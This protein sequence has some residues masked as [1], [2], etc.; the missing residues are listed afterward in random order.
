MNKIRNLRQPRQRLP[1]SKKNKKWRK[2]NLD[3]ADGYSFYHNEGVRQSLKNKIINLNL[4]N[5]KVDVRDIAQV[6][7]P[8]H[9]DASFVPENIPHHPIV[10]PK[11]DLLVG[12]ES[13]RRFDW[14]VL[15]SNSDAISKKEEEKKQFL[16][17]K[18]TEYLKANYPKEELE[19]KLAELDDYMKYSWSDIREKM[20]TQIL[21]HYYTEQDFGTI[22]NEGFKDALIMAEEIYQVDI[23]HKEP[24]LSKLNPL[25]VRAIR[26]GNSNRIEDSPLIIVE[27]HWSP[28][29]IVDHFH[30]E[31]KEKDI[32]EILD[33]GHK[34][35][36]GSYT[37]DHNNHVLLRDAADENGDPFIDSLFDIAEVNGH[38]FS[39]NY[40]D[41]EGNIRVLQLYWKS[42][43]K[44]LKV[45]YYDDDGEVQYKMMTE[46]YILD[47][48]RGEEAET[49][50]INEMWEGTKIGKDIYVKMRPRPMQFN[51]MNNPSYCHAGII[52]QIYNTNQGKAVSL[53][54]R[55]KNYQYMYDAI[56]DRLN[57]AISTNYGKIFELD[58]SK[59]PDNWEVDKWLHF[60]ITNK[61][62]V[63]DSFKEGTHGASTGK[64]AGSMNTQGGRAIDMETGNYIQQHMQLLEFIK[65]EMGEISGVSQ[66]RQGQIENRETVGGVERSVAQ[67]SHVTEYWFSTHEKVKLR[68]LQAFVET[69]KVAL[70]GDNKKTQFILDDMSIQMLNMDGDIFSEAD[71]GIICTS[72]SKSMELEQALKQHAQAFLQNGGSLST[73]IDIY[74]SD[75]ITDMRRK[76]ETAEAK[77]QEQNAKAQEEQSKQAQAQM[78]QQAELEQAKAQREEAASLRDDA[79]KRYIAELNSQTQLQLKALEDGDD[80]DGI[81]NP[82][83]DEK[84]NL[85]REKQ[86]EEQM[87]KIRK[88]DDDMKMHND[89]MQREDKKIAISKQKPVAK[90]Q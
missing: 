24:T 20:A 63:I 74:F 25:K 64:L 83:E 11:I 4:Y 37:D 61:I 36:K 90:K 46:E 55:C 41:A 47:K 67:S 22:F 35:S 10:V 72:S 54:D 18:F 69:A 60:A 85:Q 7:N 57:K 66:Q 48:N 80:G 43:K 13:K 75:S 70:K 15:V 56:W 40:T 6:V 78:Q 68:V 2:E 14:K 32:D 62:G 33:Y 30:N 39:S 19:R 5:G 59:I 38:H 44:M 81:I 76:L 27:D 8:Y 1:Y 31:L 73:I 50:W 52:G 29:R 89:K 49:I 23:I 79:T 51:K 12:E 28:N 58:I 86:R 34:S 45:K 88:L 87:I 16:L 3:A 65:M 82:G 17:A 77:I 84:I 53:L 71:Y 9:L 21:K 26:N 42:L